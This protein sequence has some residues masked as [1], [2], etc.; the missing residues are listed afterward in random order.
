VSQTAYAAFARSLALALNRLADDLEVTLAEPL[1]VVDP[2]AEKE[3]E[4]LGKRQRAIFEL[5]GLRE[6]TGM[7]AAEIAAAIDYQ[8]PNTNQTLQVMERSGYVERVPDSVPTRW[9]LV[10]KYRS[11]DPYIWAASHVKEGEW[12]TYGDIS[13]A[14]R[15]DTLAARAV[16]RAA[17]LRDEFPTPYRVLQSGGTV[18]LGWRGYGGGPEECQRRLEREGVKFVNG[19]AD[20][21]RRVTWD[22]LIERQKSDGQSLSDAG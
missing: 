16:G 11:A 2:D 20:P 7:K 9:R 6:E 17:A 18:P 1:L 13:I 12:T 8:V 21:T 4:G 14:V 22:I 10:S 3:P 15:G 5:T 19:K